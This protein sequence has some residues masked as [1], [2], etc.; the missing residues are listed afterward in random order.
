MEQKAALKENPVLMA[1]E[2]VVKDI[3]S[4]VE[5]AKWFLERKAR[6]EFSV[7]VEQETNIN[8][9]FN[10]G[11]P[12]PKVIDGHAISSVPELKEAK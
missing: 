4:S 3:K 5:T 9:T 11:V 8:L 10:N 7:K 12:R 2:T 1:R 6:H